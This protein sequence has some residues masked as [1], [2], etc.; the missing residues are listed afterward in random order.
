MCRFIFIFS[1]LINSEMQISLEIENVGESKF[2]D[3]TDETS[4]RVSQCD[5]GLW[6]SSSAKWECFEALSISSPTYGRN[7][8]NLAY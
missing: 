2:P 3:K 6:T 4:D 5:S 7:E 8:G 1:F